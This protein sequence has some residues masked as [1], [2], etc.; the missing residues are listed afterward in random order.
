VPLN[1]RRKVQVEWITTDRTL[2]SQRQFREV[3]GGHREVVPAVSA[4]LD[5]FESE[6]PAFRALHGWRS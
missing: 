6:I 5:V 4:P 1:G 2:A 3:S